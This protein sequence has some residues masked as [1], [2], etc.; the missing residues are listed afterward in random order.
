MRRAYGEQ[1][2]LDF[3]PIDAKVIKEL[4]TMDEIVNS[5]HTKLFLL[6]QDLVGDA[7]PDIGRNGMSADRV[8]RLALI[9]QK[10]GWSYEDLYTRV[11]DSIA[12]RRFCHYEYDRVPKPSTIHE[13]IKKITPETFEAINEEFKRYA[14]RQGIDLGEQVRFDSTGVESNIHYPRDSVLIGDGV[15][16][17]TRFLYQARKLFPKAEITF[18]DRCRAVKKRV[19]AISNTRDQKKRKKLYKELYAFGREVVGY[20]RAAITRLFALQGTEEEKEAARFIAREL[21]DYVR[22]L[23]K[24]LDQTDRR[25]FKD[26]KVPA[27]EKVVSIF[28]PHTDVIEKGGRET[29]FGH[30]VFLAVGCRNLVLDCLI[31]EGNPADTELFPELLGRHRTFYRRAP[32]DVATDTGFA[33]EANARCAQKSGVE[34]ISFGRGRGKKLNELLPEGPLQKILRRFRAGVEGIISALKRGVGLT[35]CLWKGWESFRAYVWSA[36]CAHNLKMLTAT[37]CARH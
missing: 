24:I 2:M 35:R 11:S 37:M 18:H 7:N 4:E 34:N 25:V 36:I 16:V 29:I 22:L 8:L 20:G 27:D 23:S 17:V 5:A 3:T 21:R 13:N 26:K 14:T 19:F 6:E 30:K 12:L 33:S 28:E 32:K 15:R 1:Q 31:E 9:K 10:Y